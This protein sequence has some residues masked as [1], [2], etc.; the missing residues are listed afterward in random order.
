MIKFL[1]PYILEF[2]KNIQNIDIKYFFKKIF[3][4]KFY[5]TIKMNFTTNL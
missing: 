2:L 1:I 4:L 5:M 3:I